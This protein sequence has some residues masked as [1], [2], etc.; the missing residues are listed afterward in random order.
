MWVVLALLIGFALGVWVKGNP[1]SV[2]AVGAAVK[3]WTIAMID[4]LRKR[5]TPP[6]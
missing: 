3:R 5:T 1:D 2:R 4:K 6:T